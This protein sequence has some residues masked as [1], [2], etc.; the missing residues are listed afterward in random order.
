MMIHYLITFLV[1]SVVFVSSQSLSTV[2][3]LQSGLTKFTSLI[4]QYPD[5]VEQLNGGNFTRMASSPT[6]VFP[7]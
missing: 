4:S 6:T 5:L 1:Y 2:L 3:S 7:H